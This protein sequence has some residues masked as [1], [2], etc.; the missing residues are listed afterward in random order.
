VFDLTA[1][2]A[3]IGAHLARDPALAPH[4]AARPGLRVPGA[5]DGFELA[6]R[7]ILGQQITVAAAT[8]LAARIAREWGEPLPAAVAGVVP[9]LT[10]TFPSADRLAGADLSVLP[11]PKARSGYLQ[12]LARAAAADPG[13]LEPRGDLAEAIGKLR[14]LPGV[15]EWT[16]QYIA[17][18]QMREPDAFPPG[19]IGLMRAMAAPGAERPTS[20]EL[21][22]RAEAWRPWRAYAA[23]HLWSSETMAEPAAEAPALKPRPRSAHDRRA[24]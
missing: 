17:M 19:D 10:H 5:W 1:D 24:A 23:L 14:S 16:A 22:A 12:A 21:Q 18:R 15:G 8:S 20:A 6:V 2:P 9:G 3:A 4:V 7:A 11:M 13:L